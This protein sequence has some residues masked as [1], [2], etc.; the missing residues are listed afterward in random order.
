ML[1]WENQVTNGQYR[2][3]EAAMTTNPDQVPTEPETRYQEL[4]EAFMAGFDAGMDQHVHWNDKHEAF[5]A[6]RQQKGLK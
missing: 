1:N 4:Y 5:E 3:I 6:F 2:L